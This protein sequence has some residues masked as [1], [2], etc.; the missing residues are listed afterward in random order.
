LV[1]SASASRSETR[2]TAFGSSREILGRDGRRYAFADHNCFACGGQNQIGMR[3]QI[4]LGEGTARTTWVAGHDF[5]GW[6]DK[7]HGGILA[8]LLD[9][10]MAWAPSSYDSWAVTAEMNLRYRAPANPGEELTAEAQVTS[11][12]RRIYHVHGTVRGED[13]RLIAE[14]DGRFLGASPTEKR[15]L[16]ERYGMPVE[17]PAAGARRE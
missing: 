15:E 9:E 16:K 10:V 4:E 6:E 14:A 1:S 12:R 3:L 2:T 8:T 7:I 11:R 5:V 17:L 13:G